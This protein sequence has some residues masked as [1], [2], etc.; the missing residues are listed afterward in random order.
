MHLQIKMK[1]EWFDFSDIDGGPKDILSLFFTVT[2]T[3]HSV[4]GFS[5]GFFLF[6]FWGGVCRHFLCLFGLVF[7]LF[8]WV[9]IFSIL[10]LLA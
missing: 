6:G 4:F 8:V 2:V 7:Y 10:Y 5:S 3:F 9:W 1:S